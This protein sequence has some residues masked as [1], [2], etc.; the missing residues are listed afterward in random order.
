[1]NNQK[2]LS[3]IEIIVSFSILSLSFIALMQSFPLALNLN[4]TSENA[5]KASY[6]A[7]EKIEELYAL[8]YVNFST[9]TIEAKHSLSADPANYL[10]YFQRQTVVYFVDGNLQTSETDT[11]M[12]KVSVTIYYT[13]SFSKSEKSY[14]TIT[15][16]S[17]W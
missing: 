1:M 2:G 17:Q 5:T 12:K 6:L 11:G 9:G 14:T 16:I 10:Y 15:L 13:N 8:G 4:K 3:L 7:Q